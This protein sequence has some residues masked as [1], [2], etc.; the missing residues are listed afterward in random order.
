[1]LLQ[2]LYNFEDFKNNYFEL[3][4]IFEYGETDRID[5]ENIEKHHIY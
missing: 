2:M 4:V 3:I 1:M 5:V